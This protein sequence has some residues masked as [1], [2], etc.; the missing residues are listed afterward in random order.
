MFGNVNNTD[1]KKQKKKTLTEN[2][3]IKDACVTDRHTW[4]DKGSL[5]TEARKQN[6]KKPMSSIVPSVSNYCFYELCLEPSEVQGTESLKLPVKQQE[7]V[8]EG[9]F[10]NKYALAVKIFSNIHFL[11]INREIYSY[12]RRYDKFLA[13]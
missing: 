3:N 5:H 13:L 4:P 8:F 11:E 10:K 12:R 9:F 6:I 2:K 7:N 1:E